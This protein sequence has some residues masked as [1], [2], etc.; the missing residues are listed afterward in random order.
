MRAFAVFILLAG[1]AVAQTPS[2]L[3]FD[4]ASVKINEPFL[5]HDNR[6]QGTIETSPGSLT[7]R[8]VTWLD[9]LTWAYRLQVAQIAGPSW[10]E[11]ETYDVFAKTGRPADKDEI[12]LMLQALLAERFKLA[13]HRE[14]REIAGLALAES[15][16]G[17]KM[18]PPESEDQPS[19]T[20]PELAE[21]VAADLRI[22]VA[23]MTGLKGSY[24]FTFAL[25]RPYFDEYRKMPP[26]FDPIT[27]FQ[28][29]MQK[30]LGLKLESHKV[31]I[32]VLVIDHVER[33]PIEN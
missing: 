25:L 17:N 8:K 5:G 2:P 29:G 14:N 11:L 26:P 30:E 32:E 28:A 33:K 7:M 20:M 31:P 13:C 3:V 27:A 24:Q 9:M 21:M 22:P 6:W 12:R 16:G 4:V 10:F 1:S 23:D 19:V 15:K 18:K